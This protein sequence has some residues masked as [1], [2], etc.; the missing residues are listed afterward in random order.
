[1]LVDLILSGKRALVVG[2]SEE[3]ER[4]AVQL[5]QEGARVSV[6]TVGRAT[7][8][9][10]EA[11][12]Q[13][14][15]ELHEPASVDALKS[16][17]GRMRP[18]LTAICSGDPATDRE[19]AAF[20]RRV[21]RLVYVVDRPEL[22]DVNMTAVARVGDVRI[23]ISTGGLSPA[24]AGVLRRKVESA[25]GREDVLQ[26]RLQGRVRQKIRRSIADPARRKKLVYGLIHDRG[27]SSMLNANQYEEAELRA[28]RIIEAERSLSQK[29]R[30]IAPRVDRRG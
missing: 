12:S 16:A 9:L 27:I 11:S 25:I 28:L 4:R 10:R 22:N 13:Y 26:V 6:L 14:E 23:A 18:F 19:I 15:F 17:A 5:S 7:R 2:E 3:A 21:S 20:A 1:L 29:G 24:M 30:A 8:A